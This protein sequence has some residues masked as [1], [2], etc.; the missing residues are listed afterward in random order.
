MAAIFSLTVFPAFAQSVRIT[1]TVADAANEPLPGVNVVVKGTQNGTVTDVNGKYEISVSGT[2]AVLT[3]SYIGY[4]S[5]EITVGNRQVINL[6]LT[7]EVGLIDEVVV[8]GYGT[9]KKVNLTGAVTTVKYDQELENRP[10]TDVS[11]ALQGRV[12][13]VWATQFSGNPGDNGATIRI[14]GYGSLGTSSDTRDPNPLVLIDGIEGKMSEVEPNSIESITVLK[15]AASA[16]IY[17]SRAANGVILIESKK[18]IQDRVTLSYNGYVGVQQLASSPEFVTNSAD[19]MDM[20]NEARRNTGTSEIFPADVIAAFRTGTDPY[21]YPNTDFVKEIYHEAFT[22]QHTVSANVGGRNSSTYLSLSYMSND[23][24]LRNTSSERY[25]LNLNNET[26]VKK[27]LRVGARARMQHRTNLAPGYVP[28]STA[29]GGSGIQRVIYLTAYGHPYATPYLQDGKTFG[30]SQPVFLTGA[31]AGQPISD[32]RNPFP[33]LNNGEDRTINNFFR[34]NVF[35]TADFADW[36]HLTVNY[37]GQ[38]TNND[39]DVYSS[40][41]F[42]YLDL[43]GNGMTK[44]LDYVSTLTNSRR[45][46]DEWYSTFFANLNFDKTFNEIHELSGVL[47]YQQESLDKRY[48]FAS[49]INPPKDNLHQ[50]SAGTE[51]I[52]GEGNRYQWRMLS[53]FG[54]VNYALASKYLFEVNLRADASSRFNPEKRWG[55]FPSLSAGWRLGEES[56]I[57]NLGIFD[58]LKV[59]ASWGQLGNQNTGSRNNGDYFPYLTVIAQEYTTSYNYG[60]SFAPGAAVTALSEY[61]LTWETT[62][63]TD[64][65]VDIGVLGNRLNIEADYFHKNTSDILV[66]LP[67]PLAM[68]GLT[69]P[70]ENIGE[71]INKGIEFNAIWQDRIRTS[72]LSYRL[73]ANITYVDNKVTKFQGGKSPDQTFLIREGYS[74][75]SVYGYNWE[76]IYQSDA[77]AAEH[78]K[79][80]SIKPKA[81]DLR[82]TDVNQDG[83]IDFNDMDVIG[84]T[85]PKYNY[86]L[87]GNLTWKDFDLN[88]SFSGSAGYTSYFLNPWSQPLTTSGGTITKRWYDRWTPENPSTE[89]PRL[90]INYSWSGYASSFWTAQMWWLKLK[91]VQLGYN[92]PKNVVSKLQLQRLYVYMNASELYT[93][94]T[95]DYEGFDPERDGSGSGTYHYPVPRVYTLGLNITF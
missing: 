80:N 31:N 10:I 27:W 79:N 42:A 25:S 56:F 48:T 61:N 15:D 18:G 74:F 90:A 17:G 69:A 54:R 62:T 52:Q 45:I 63:T 8:V 50:V 14:R 66:A 86:G 57:K 77:E 41:N 38:Y 71:V 29:G 87:N 9:Q 19:Y 3:F 40:P 16:A 82:Y 2:N 6:T 65:G 85:I 55:Y 20:W 37:S 92:L 67:L 53:Y 70:V 5:Q 32:T 33:D 28:S 76:G 64:I 49:R 43:N 88:F 68:G 91:N 13:G 73:G 58:N 89:L 75:Q 24:I 4:V 1:G 22:T 34:G 7:E 51:N 12:P 81:G 47:G 39:R 59:R 78:M 36:L 94:V 11:Q 30:A 95:K 46:N 83:K 93:W 44:S 26:K 35:A 72:N 23:G 60:N 21:K 84:N